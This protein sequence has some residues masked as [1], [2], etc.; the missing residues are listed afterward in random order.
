M[1]ESCK[2]DFALVSRMGKTVDYV[3]FEIYNNR[4]AYNHGL[5]KWRKATTEL[6][7]E[8]KAKRADTVYA[9]QTR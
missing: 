9:F 7:D 2:R 5:D 8:F 3:T 1:K 4:I 6:M